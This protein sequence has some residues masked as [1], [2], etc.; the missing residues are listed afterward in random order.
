MKNKRSFG[1]KGPLLLFITAFIWG[2]A[3]IAQEIGGEMGAFT[4]LSLRS[5]LAT[6]FLLPVI[7]VSDK[8]RKKSGGERYRLDKRTL[9]GGALCGTALFLGSILQQIGINSGTSSGKAAFITAL[10]IIILPIIGFIMGKKTPFRIVICAISAV[11]GFYFLCFNGDSLGISSGDVLLLIGA[12]A[13]SAH[14]LIVDRFSPKTD[15]VR[16]S[17]VQFFTC[18]VLSGIGV[19]IFETPSIEI[20]SQNV[21][22][23]LYAGVLSSGVAYTLQIIGQKSTDPTVATMIMSLESV[24]AMISNIIFP[25]LNDKMEPYVPSLREIIGCVII[26]AA[27]IIAQIPSKKAAQEV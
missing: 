22:A 23:L 21:I 8:I 24:F 13:F 2:S 10:Y 6:V 25:L 3:F 16:L 5:A 27:I 11:I 12:V 14:I 19:L 15:G 17:C 7:F 26:F 9:I 1:L 4:L 20:I 18:F